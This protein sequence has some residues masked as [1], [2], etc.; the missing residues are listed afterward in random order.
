MTYTGSSAYTGGT[1]GTAGSTT[2]G[3]KGKKQVEPA[4][5]TTWEGRSTA[6]FVADQH[7][8]FGVGDDLRVLGDPDDYNN[9]VTSQG[10]RVTS[11]RELR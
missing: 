8:Y 11:W 6:P 1:G 2:T 10:V 3:K 9:G 4:T 7:V 5:I